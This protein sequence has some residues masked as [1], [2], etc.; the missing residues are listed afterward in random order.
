[1]RCRASARG[2]TLVEVL[3]VVALIALLG[4]TAMLGPGLLRS[5]RLRTTATAIVSGVRLGLTRANTTGRAVRLVF[6]LDERR[7]SMEEAQ[8][9]EF[10]R[11]KDVTGGADASTEA[12]KKAKEEAERTVSGPR[13]PALRFK[14]ISVLTDP[15]DSK[16][17][18]PFG[19]GVEI[20][21]VQ[22]EHDEEPVT[23]GR[24]YLYFWPGG[25][26]ERATI[27]LKRSDGTLDE[28][29]S[30]VVSAL[31]GRASIVK[32][33]PKLAQPPEDPEGSGFG[34]PKEEEP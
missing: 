22:T 25:M 3:I 13:A 10:T 2:L 16:K 30:V 28:G 31:N 8:T 12:E 11:K 26:T 23:Q 20:A 33:E 34:N 17:G 15:E 29:L 4:G 7:L 19:A 21:S 9:S 1:M 5:T 24:A 14:P 18:R 27:R 6:D 32:G